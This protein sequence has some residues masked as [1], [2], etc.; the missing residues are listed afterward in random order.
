M[1]NKNF[2]AIDYKTGKVEA[3]KLKIN[4]FEGLTLDLAN[5]KIIQLKQLNEYCLN[6]QKNY[7]ENEIKKLSQMSIINPENM[8]SEQYTE[9]NYIDIAS[10]KG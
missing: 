4:T 5:D 9:I 10:V 8:K 2:F 6:N 3:N 7:G 1:S